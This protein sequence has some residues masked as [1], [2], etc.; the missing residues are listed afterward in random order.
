MRGRDRIGIINDMLDIIKN[1][2]DQIK[3]THIMYKANLS[4]EM[5]TNYMNELLTKEFIIEKKDK[6]GKRTYTLT[7]KGF[8]FLRDY[9]I[10]KGFVDSYDLNE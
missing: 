10:I 4:S 1:K 5:L 7:E 2:G 9:K 8:N 3:P 6:K